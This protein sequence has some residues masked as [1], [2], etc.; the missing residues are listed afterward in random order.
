MNTLGNDLLDYAEL[1]S[2]DTMTELVAIGRKGRTEKQK[3]VE[4]QRQHEQELADKQIQG[5]AVEKD[6]DRAWEGDQN[7]KDRQAGIMR[8]EI[9]AQG[10][11]AD[12]KADQ[13]SF[14]NIS[15]QTDMALKEMKTNSDIQLNQDKLESQKSTDNSKLALLDEQLRLETRKLDQKDREI[16]NSRYIAEINKN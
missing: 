6:K 10:R 16:N 15:A 7:D 1:F 4:A 12:K 5:A 3:D 8:E 14:K 2:A 11:A 9:Q 13:A